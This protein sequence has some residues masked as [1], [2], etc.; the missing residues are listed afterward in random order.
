MKHRIGIIGGGQLGRMLGFAAKKLGFYVTVL[1]PTPNCPAGQVVDAQ[2]IADF[3]DEKAIRELAEK[4]DFLT[5][6]IELANADILEEIAKSGVA[7]NP[8]AKT[9][10]L[11]KDKLTQKEFLKKLGL[12]VAGFIPVE[13]DQDVLEATKQF[14]YPVLLKTRFDGYDG[15]GNFLVKKRADIN[16]G[17]EKLAGRKL[18]LEEYIDFDKELAIMMARGSKGEIKSYPVVETVHKNNICQTVFAP[19]PVADSIQKKT[20][21][22]A[23]RTMNYL[24]GAGVFGIEMF[25]TPKGEVL[26]NEIAPRVHNSGHYT[27]EACHTSQFEQHI[28]AIT[29]LPL[30]STDMLVPAAVMVNILGDRHG[31]AEVIGLEKALK[32]PGVAIHIYG[33]EMTKPERKMGHITALAKTVERSHNKALIALRCIGV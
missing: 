21:L 28:R 18:Y 3:K 5:F 31:N 29:G 25:M 12:P 7:V 2:I 23:I 9:L 20:E 11:V 33:K 27:I 19:A 14:G 4:S 15:R 10:N 13:D 24:D 1:D 22:L 8:S 26:I 30:G 6:E 32:I 17:L 16:V